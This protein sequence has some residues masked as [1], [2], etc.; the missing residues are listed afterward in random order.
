[1]LSLKIKPSAFKLAKTCKF[2][3]FPSNS[4]AKF[5]KKPKQ[6]NKKIHKKKPAPKNQPQKA[7]G[8]LSRKGSDISISVFVTFLGRSDSTNR[9]MDERTKC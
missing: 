8:V 2:Q 6:T 1:M 9:L 5:I 3:A 7:I 4:L